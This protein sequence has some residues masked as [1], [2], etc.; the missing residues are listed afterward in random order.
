M[1]TQIRCADAV[2]LLAEFS[3]Q[4]RVAAT[5]FGHAVGQQNHCL[6]RAFR[7]PLIDEEAAV[8]ACGQPE[9]VVD[10]RGSFA[11][12]LHLAAQGKQPRCIV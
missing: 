6:E 9:R 7:Q 2:T 8:V 1:A 10:H 5:V 12:G 4:A 3:R 11:W